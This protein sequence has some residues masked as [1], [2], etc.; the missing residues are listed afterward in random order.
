LFWKWVLWTNPEFRRI[1]IGS[2][3][4]LSASILYP[5]FLAFLAKYLCW[6]TSHG[7]TR[8]L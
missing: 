1:F 2:W 7:F 4:F 3:S 5:E 8:I 6:P